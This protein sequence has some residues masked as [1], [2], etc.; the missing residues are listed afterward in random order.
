MTINSNFVINN[1]S[2]GKLVFGIFHPRIW[3]WWKCNFFRL[4]RGECTILFADGQRLP[5][6]LQIELA[7]CTV[8]RRA[9]I[10]NRKLVDYFRIWAFGK[11]ETEV[12]IHVRVTIYT[13]MAIRPCR[14]SETRYENIFPHASSSKSYINTS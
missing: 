1:I 3:N 6:L 14:T 13:S 10:H 5:I 11:R 2:Y 9:G 4:P 12:R 7:E 8:A